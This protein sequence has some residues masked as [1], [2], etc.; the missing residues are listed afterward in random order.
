MTANGHDTSTH[1][2]TGPAC[3]GSTTAGIAYNALIVAAS[4]GST[5]V[6]FA[7]RLAVRVGSSM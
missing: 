7:N 3:S 1:Q 2:S 6:H 4:A 5:L